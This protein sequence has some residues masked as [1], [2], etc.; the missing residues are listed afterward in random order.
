MN[1]ELLKELLARR[2]D[3]EIKFLNPDSDESYHESFYGNNIPIFCRFDEFD[4][5]L[6]FQESERTEVVS[7]FHEMI[8]GMG[9]RTAETS[10]IDKQFSSDLRAKAAA[11]AEHF[12]KYTVLYWQ[13]YLRVLIAKPN[14]QVH[15]M[16]ISFMRGVFDGAPKYEFGYVILRGADTKKK[17]TDGMCDAVGTEEKPMG[18]EVNEDSLPH[19][20]IPEVLSEDKTCVDATVQQPMPGDINDKE[21]FAA[22]QR[23]VDIVFEYSKNDGVHPWMEECRQEAANPYYNR[24]E[25]LFLEAPGDYP[26]TLWTPWGKWSFAY[27]GDGRWG[28]KEEGQKSLLDQILERLGA[29][30]YIPLL[31]LDSWGEYG[32]VYALHEVDGVALPV[33]KVL[34][35]RASVE[36]FA[37]YENVRKTW[38]DLQNAWNLQ[39]LS[40]KEMPGKRA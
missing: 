29:T 31:H 14:I 19:D 1:A 5:L 22:V 24:T 21:L 10:L 4:L 12:G 2:E 9:G 25:G 35:R 11:R 39:N 16:Y 3:E 23:I 17:G 26:V 37:E 18:I 6:S 34:D 27:G 15:I 13:E 40:S 33:P 30:L 36:E 28:R 32:P 8:Q 20:S 7:I 38:K